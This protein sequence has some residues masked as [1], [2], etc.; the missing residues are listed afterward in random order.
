MMD[1]MFKVT[2]IRSTIEW[3]GTILYHSSLETLNRIVK[4]LN[5]YAHL[6][7]IM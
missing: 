3:N 7:K 4:S 2:H 5:P 6:K 1:V